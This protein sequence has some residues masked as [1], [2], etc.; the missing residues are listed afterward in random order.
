MQLLKAEK[1]DQIWYFTTYHRAEVY[2]GI[3]HNNI[4]LSIYEKN[5]PKGWEFEW[6]D[7][8]QVFTKYI[9]PEP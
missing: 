7:D 9:N 3:P 5:K 8:I 1:D 2:C 6:V 4:R